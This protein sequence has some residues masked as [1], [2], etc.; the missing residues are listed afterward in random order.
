MAGGFD[1]RV[2]PENW[3]P[4]QV[5]LVLQTQWRCCPAGP[6]GLDY[7][8]LPLAL[9]QCDVPEDQRKDVFAALQIIELAALDALRSQKDH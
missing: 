9:A 7:G 4:L 3:L 1:E 8:A 6:V 2:Y 5:F